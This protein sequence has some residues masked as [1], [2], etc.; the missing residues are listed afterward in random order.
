MVL[1]LWC[2][3]WCSPDCELSFGEVDGDEASGLDELSVA[4]GVVG[5]EGGVA[6]AGGTCFGGGASLDGGFWSGGGVDCC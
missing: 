5:V 6:S 3:F 1:S 2:F 4:G